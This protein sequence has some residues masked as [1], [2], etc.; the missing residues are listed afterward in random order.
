MKEKPQNK[1][2][3][4][5]YAFQ[6][7]RILLSAIE[8]DIFSQIPKSDGVSGKFL[9]EKLN[10]NQRACERLCNALCAME[11]LSKKASLYFH[12]KDSYRL[13]HHSSSEFVAGLYHTNH[14][15][16]NW[17][18]LSDIVRHGK[19][20]QKTNFEKQKPYWVKAFIGAMHDRA[21]RQATSQLADID[22][23]NVEKM[24]DVGGGS[25][26]FSMQ[27]VRKNKKIQATVFDLPTVT[28]ITDQYI[29]DEGYKDNISTVNGDYLSDPIEG[30]YD[31]IFLSAVIHSNSSEQNQLLIEKCYNVLNSGG[32][33][34]IQDFLMNPDRSGPLKSATFAINMLVA[35]SKGDTYTEEE[36]SSWLKKSGFTNIQRKDVPFMVSQIIGSKE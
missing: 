15:W 30:T 11:V 14:T 32:R 28:P 5:A 26:A 19:P 4:I 18:N 10:L 27:F 9:S 21:K 7:S 16:D 24:L 20:L 3:Q 13:L 23:S 2:L 25:G 12:T 1:I 17:N 8:L 36:I 22:V 29:L 33:I 6:E 31:L 34:I 35:T